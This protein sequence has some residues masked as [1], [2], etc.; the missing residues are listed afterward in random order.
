MLP[1]MTEFERALDIPHLYFCRLRN[2]RCR[3]ANGRPLVHRTYYAAEAEVEWNSRR[4]LLYMPFRREMVAH[5]EELELALAG[6]DLPFFC[7]HQIFYNEMLVDGDNRADLIL[8]ELPEGVW[9]KDSCLSTAEVSHRLSVLDTQM[10][11]VG[12]SHNNLSPANIIYDKSGVLRPM[13]YWYASLS[14]DTKDDTFA[15]GVAF[16]EEEAC[17]QRV[18]DIELGYNAD[19]TSYRGRMRDGM[20]RFME[21][22]KVGFYDEDGRVAIAPTYNSAGDFEEGR[23]VVADE[24]L[25]M[26]AIDKSGRTVVP[27]IYD[28]ITF[29]VEQGLFFATKGPLLCVIDYCGEIISQQ[30]YDA[31]APTDPTSQD[32][33]QHIEV[34][35]TDD[36]S[37]R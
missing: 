11:R 3:C 20:V 37:R 34:L 15:T 33:R 31:D 2:L 5:I 23:A 16:A 1:T 25:K 7:H 12:F 10:R 24:A 36:E 22:G 26:G 4:Y 18:E 19:A 13:R 8:Q 27:L 9:L 14:P 21:G 30:S 28:D 35:D 29:D 17:R 6:K 32:P